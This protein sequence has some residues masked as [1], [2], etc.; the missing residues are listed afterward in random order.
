MDIKTCIDYLRIAKKKSPPKWTFI[1]H[2]VNI[3]PMDLFNPDSENDINMVGFSK[4]AKA[5]LVKLFTS[6]YSHRYWWILERAQIMKPIYDYK[7]KIPFNGIAL[8]FKNSLTRAEDRTEGLCLFQRSTSKMKVMRIAA[9]NNLFDS[10]FDPRNYTYNNPES[11]VDN[12]K[13]GYYS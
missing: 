9:I 13:N 7:G 8:N 5:L 12:Y 1:H 11:I 6:G 2:C 10:N 3:E 4:E